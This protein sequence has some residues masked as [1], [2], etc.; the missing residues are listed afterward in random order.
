MPGR[1]SINPAG[2]TGNER[3]VLVSYRAYFS[4]TSRSLSCDEPVPAPDLA[5][6]LPRS[7]SLNLRS[8]SFLPPGPALV[9]SDACVVLLLMP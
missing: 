4:S 9:R 1:I 5:R 7:F 3:T 2:E 8:D 6:A